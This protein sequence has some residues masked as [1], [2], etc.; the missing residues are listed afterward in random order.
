MNSEIGFALK[1]ASILHLM[2]GKFD[3]NKICGEIY[4]KKQEFGFSKLF[5]NKNIKCEVKKDKFSEIL[6]KD[7]CKLQIETIF[8]L[9]VS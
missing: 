4:N 9:P 7:I 2:K 3:N 6:K 1:D 5:I 8:F